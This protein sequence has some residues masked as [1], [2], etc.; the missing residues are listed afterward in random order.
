MSADVCNTC[1]EDQVVVA[2]E[3]IELRQSPPQLCVLSPA[4]A[5]LQS[6]S[7]AL[8]CEPKVSPQKHWLELWV[9]KYLKLAHHN[10]H[11][12]FVI[13]STSMYSN[14]GQSPDAIGKMPDSQTA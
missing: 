6:P 14:D 7:S 11:F 5:S 2:V 13:E 9:P 1:A 3:K 8:P 12:S 10:A 4:H